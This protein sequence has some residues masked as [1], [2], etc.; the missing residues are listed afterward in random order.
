MPTFDSWLQAYSYS[1]DHQFGFH[2]LEK[3]SKTL[4]CKEQNKYNELNYRPK[5]QITRYTFFPLTH[6]Y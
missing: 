3:S 2:S 6:D 5:I 4:L 1:F